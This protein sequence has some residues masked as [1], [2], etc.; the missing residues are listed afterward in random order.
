M[1]E[2]YRHYAKRCQFWGWITDDLEQKCDW[3]NKTAKTRIKLLFGIVSTRQ[4]CR[5]HYN[6]LVREFDQI[7]KKRVSGK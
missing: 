4:L 3:C 2:N 6:K 1:N 5:E 7:E